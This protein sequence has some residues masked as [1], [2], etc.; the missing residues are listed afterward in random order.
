MAMLATSTLWPDLPCLG[1]GHARAPEWWIG[2][3]R[4]SADPVVH[5]PDLAIQQIGSDDLEVIVGRVGERAAAVAFAER[6]DARHVGAQLLVHGD[7]AARIDCDA[8]SV[9]AQIIGVRPPSGREQQMR[10][11]ERKVRVAADQTEFDA[12]L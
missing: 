10:P 6:P 1:F 3:E 4:I 2:V 11:L 5:R 9:K 7:E 12:L 8:R